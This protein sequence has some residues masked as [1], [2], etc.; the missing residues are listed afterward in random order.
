MGIVYQIRSDKKKPRERRGLVGLTMAAG[1]PNARMSCWLY[2]K[3]AF[4]YVMGL[5]NTYRPHQDDGL[6]NVVINKLELRVLLSV[7]EMI[8]CNLRIAAT[9]RKGDRNCV[10][11]H[12]EICY[13]SALREFNCITDVKT[14]YSARY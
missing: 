5:M 10:L 2:Q 6:V 11:H 4:H 8:T 7:L 14:F 12:V 3:L 9:M 13:V 1:V